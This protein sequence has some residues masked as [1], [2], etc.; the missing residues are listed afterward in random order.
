M[1]TLAVLALTL[2]DW[3][4]RLDPNGTT[5][6]VAELLGQTNAILADAVFM[7]G[8]LPTGHR[9]VV[10]TG[11]PTVYWR[12]LNARRAH[13]QVHHRDG[14]RDLRHAGGLQRGR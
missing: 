5:A 1:A 11:L 8:N 6:D 14:G 4:A 2:A 10:R 12:A 9:V 13:Q 3:A 7:E